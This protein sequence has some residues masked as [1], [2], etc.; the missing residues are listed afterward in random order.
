MFIYTNTQHANEQIKYIMQLFCQYC[1]RLYT[2]FLFLT[3]D[4]TKNAYEIYCA[5]LLSQIR[6]RAETFTVMWNLF[7]LQFV[8]GV[9]MLA[10]GNS[11]LHE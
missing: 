2:H 5:D 11:Y 4:R 1:A 8:D 3:M 7:R 9:P 10:A 6:F